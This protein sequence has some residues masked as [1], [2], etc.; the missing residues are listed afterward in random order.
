MDA[1][2]IPAWTIEGDLWEWGIPDAPAFDPLAAHTGTRVLGT[3]LQGNGRY[4]ADDSTRIATP[5]I[6][7]TRYTQVRLQYRRWLTIEDAFY[8]Q[9]TIEANGTPVWTNATDPGGTLNHLDREWRF[10][11]VDVTAQAASGA[12]T[13]A[14][15]LAS[16]AS[17]EYGGWTLDDVCVV[18][19][20]RPGCGDGAVTEDELC[21]DGNVT[22]GDGCSATCVTEEAPPE[23]ADGGCCGVATDPTGPV[24]LCMFGLLGLRRRRRPR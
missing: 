13:L 10:H 12:L 17:G 20:P 11:D 4:L 7:T 18:G 15:T 6:D 22:D 5:A 24:L 1:N 19:I 21:D 8:D 16:D 9:A 14:F 23:P 3:R 2:P